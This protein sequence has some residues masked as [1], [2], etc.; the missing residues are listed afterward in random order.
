M[1]G[2]AGRVV[3]AWHFENHHSGVQ[4]TWHDLGMDAYKDVS[5]KIEDTSSLVLT[6]LEVVF[7]L[8]KFIDSTSLEIPTLNMYVPG[9]CSPL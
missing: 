3:A 9:Q 6:G 4:V 8:P 2:L 5:R 7:L 1:Q